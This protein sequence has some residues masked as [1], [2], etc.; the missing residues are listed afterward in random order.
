MKK[1]LKIAFI[2]FWSLFVLSPISWAVVTSFK[3]PAA[4]NNGA[5]FIPWV[6]FKPTLDG[7]KDILGI[8]GYSNLIPNLIN[9]VIITRSEEHTSELQSH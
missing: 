6:Q 4:V 8:S 9:S 2:T 7:W 5:T 3:P 1:T